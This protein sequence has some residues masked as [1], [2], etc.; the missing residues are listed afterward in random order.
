LFIR[1]MPS[2]KFCSGRCWQAN[3][4]AKPHKQATARAIRR[5]RLNETEYARLVGEHGM[6][7]MICGTTNGKHRLAVDHDH[8]RGTI[9]GLLCHRCNT[10]LGM[11]QD[12]PDRL[13]AA[14]RYLRERN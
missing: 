3:E 6:L 5:R 9:R 1:T 2:Q 7:C 11:Y 4:K 8:E 13:E 10:G 12:D 14:A